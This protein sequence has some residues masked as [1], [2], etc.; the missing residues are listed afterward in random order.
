MATVE[1]NERDLMKN[2]TTTV[3]VNSDWRVGL[4]LLVMRFGAWITGMAFEVENA[5]N[6]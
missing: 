6:D 4:G 5:K 3:R 2:I 1:F